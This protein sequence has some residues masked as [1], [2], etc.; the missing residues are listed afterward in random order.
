[1]DIFKKRNYN[2]RKKHFR[3]HKTPKMHRATT[4]DMDAMTL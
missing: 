4:A 1:M 2:A 3:T